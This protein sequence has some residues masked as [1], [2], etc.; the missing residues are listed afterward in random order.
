MAVDRHVADRVSPQVQ[1]QQWPISVNLSSEPSSKSFL[2]STL[3]QLGG[4]QTL[5]I[6]PSPYPGKVDLKPLAII[7]IKPLETIFW[8]PSNP[9]N[10]YAGIVLE[11]S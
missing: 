1:R 10:W 9:F 6:W 11:D 7:S 2:I 3:R 4:T 5:A 8:N